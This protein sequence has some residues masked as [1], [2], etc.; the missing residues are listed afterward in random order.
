MAAKRSETISDFYKNL[1]GRAITAHLVSGETV[2]GVVLDV[3]AGDLLIQ[4]TGY[5]DLVLIPK[6]GLAA[7]SAG[8][9][10]TSAG[11]PAS[12]TAEGGGEA[13]PSI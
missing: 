12:T 3:D 9:G 13:L 5:Q 4:R 11:A 6:H 8:E 1:I 7:L 10:N 2:N